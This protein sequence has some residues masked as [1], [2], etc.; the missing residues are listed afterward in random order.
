MGNEHMIAQG[1]KVDFA[2]SKLLVPP[3]RAKAHLTAGVWLVVKEDVLKERIEDVSTPSTAKNHT[4]AF[5]TRVRGTTAAP[6]SFS[7][8]FGRATSETQ[9]RGPLAPIQIKRA[10]QILGALRLSARTRPD[11]SYAVSMAASVQMEDL[12]EYC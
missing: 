8:K 7:T 10:Q 3:H 11:L 6:E 1:G 9:S 5:G 4:G 2:S 12:R